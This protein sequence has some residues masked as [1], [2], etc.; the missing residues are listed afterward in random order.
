MLSDSQA[1]QH[2]VPPTAFPLLAPIYR[3]SQ[4]HLPRRPLQPH[5]PLRHKLPK[6]PSPNP[7]LTNHPQRLRVRIRIPKRPDELNLLRQ[8]RRKRQRRARRAHPDQEHFRTGLRGVDRELRGGLGACTFEHG[9]E[10]FGLVEDF[11]RRH[12]VFV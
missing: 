3:R 10:A 5:N 4:S 11:E 7:S 12:G 2:H 9:V 1:Q 6:H 8:R